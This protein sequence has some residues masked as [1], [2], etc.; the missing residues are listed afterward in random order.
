MPTTKTYK[1]DR[2]DKFSLYV[3]ERLLPELGLEN[4]KFIIEPTDKGCHSLITFLDINDFKPLV[5]R[6]VRK[7]YKLQRILKNTY[8]LR[9]SGFNAPEVLYVDDS[10]KT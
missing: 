5:I 1:A 7:K 2:N 8:F 6:G 9:Q 3:K 4:S 10:R